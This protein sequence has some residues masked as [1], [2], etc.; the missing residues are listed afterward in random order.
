MIDTLHLFEASGG[1]KIRT[2]GLTGMT[3]SLKPETGETYVT[4]YL[5][6]LQVYAGERGISIKG[7][8]AK[9]LNGTN[10]RTL[11]R[12][13]VIEAISQIQDAL[14][15]NLS[16]AKVTRLDLAATIETRYPPEAYYP[17]LGN[18]PR[19]YR[20]T[21]GSTLYYSVKCRRLLFYDKC[22]ELGRDL[23]EQWR[24]KNLLRFE[25]QF[26]GKVAR[27]LKR[28]RLEVQ[29][30]FCVDVFR[31]LKER[32][33]QEFRQIHKLEPLIKDI[34]VMRTPKDYKDRLLVDH[35]FAKGIDAINR[36]IEIMK[37]LGNMKPRNVS[38]LKSDFKEMTTGNSQG[39][40]LI[41]ELESKVFSY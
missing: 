15:V 5:R 7:S 31:D 4:G 30:L 22:K 21:E 3:E 17:L 38:R 39:N 23:P 35:V 12:T 36:D 2:E 10:L 14:S 27:Q 16:K 32:W 20:G 24:G 41:N 37:H 8:L 34:E 9:F 29:D 33:K 18:C 19:M 11:N 25:A 28:K 13:E 6:N 40:S 1:I 26:R